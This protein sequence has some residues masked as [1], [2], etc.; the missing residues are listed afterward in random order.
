MRVECE[1]GAREGHRSSPS[2]EAVFVVQCV[3]ETLGVSEEDADAEL[4]C[5][6]LRGDHGVPMVGL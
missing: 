3:R 1:L 5:E 4:A 6:R 2:L